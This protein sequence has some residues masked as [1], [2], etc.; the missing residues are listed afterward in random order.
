MLII[1]YGKYSPKE[2]SSKHQML[3]DEKSVCGYRD[4]AEQFGH[5]IYM[6]PQKVRKP[7]EHCFSEKGILDFISKYPDAIVWSVKHDPAKD[8]ILKKIKNKKVYYSC[9]AK[10]PYNS[11]CNIS[12]VDTK[13]R[14]QQNAV[15]YVKGKDPKFWA[16]SYDTR[17]EFD[18][19]LIGKRCDKNEVYFLHELDKVGKTRKVL[20]IGGEQH[21]SKINVNNVEVEYTPFL[22]KESVRDNILRARIGIL[23]TELEVEGFPQSYLEMTMC[24]LP[25]VYNLKAPYNKY[26]FLD[27]S[28]S[29]RTDK[30]HLIEAAEF[31]KRKYDKSMIYYTRLSAAKNYSLDVSYER[32]KQCIK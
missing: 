4:Y 31:L 7:W 32:I 11:Y 6:T 29:V 12:L 18:Y 26:Y 14:I 20:W 30:K 15:L 3:I 2:Y 10:N 21:K 24:G 13:E 25:V 5:I 27:P 8:E 1:L 9:C 19:L 28:C 16:S 23:F 22:N 17:K